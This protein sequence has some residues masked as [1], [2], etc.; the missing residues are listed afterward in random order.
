MAGASEIKLDVL[1]N[2]DGA[3]SPLVVVGSKTASFTT[4]GADLA[5]NL[6][7]TSVTVT[8]YE[9]R[10]QW[11]ATVVN[12]NTVAFNEEI[13]VSGQEFSG[14]NWDS[15]G[16]T[17]IH[18]MAPGEAKNVS[19]TFWRNSDSTQ[20]KVILKSNNQIIKESTPITLEP[21]NAKVELSNA[22][23]SKQGAIA[24]W[25]VAVNNNGNILLSNVRVKTYHRQANGAWAV[26]SNTQNIGSLGIGANSSKN[27]IFTPGASTQF[28]FEVVASSFSENYG[29]IIVG[30]KELVF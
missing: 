12:N 28:K 20:F 14:G 23:V 29:D 3:N 17:K 10:F 18:Q 8:P 9:G 2:Y 24:S 1:V 13:S 25:S 22:Q 19:L 27:G 26:A 30:I 7:V 11:T 15:C 4:S 6:D 5:G 21:I 16:F